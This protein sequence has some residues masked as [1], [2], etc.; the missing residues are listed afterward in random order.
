MNILYDSTF[1]DIKK[2]LAK[3]RDSGGIIDFAELSLILSPSRAR[4][5]IRNLKKVGLII[6]D[7]NTFK[8]TEIGLKYLFS[9]KSEKKK[10]LFSCLNSLKPY[11]AF[12]EKIKYEKVEI[13]EIDYIQNIWGILAINVN[14]RVLSSAFPLFCAI[15]QELELGEDKRG[16]FCFFKNYLDLLKNLSQLNREFADYKKIEIQKKSTKIEQIENKAER[17]P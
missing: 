6:N 1:E 11:R 12:F 13:F 14:K 16:S 10:I 8:M 3:L 5:S 7:K 4:T 17:L 15:L 2:I 9:Q